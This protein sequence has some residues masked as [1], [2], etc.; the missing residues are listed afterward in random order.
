MLRSREA[1]SPPGEVAERA[2]SA[3]L[4]SDFP[5]QWS[6]D[7]S[8]RVGAAAKLA[9]GR[10]AGQQAAGGPEQVPGQPSSRGVDSTPRRLRSAY[11]AAAQMALEDLGAVEGLE[12]FVSVTERAL[13]SLEPDA[14]ARAVAMRRGSSQT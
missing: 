11:V 7:R 2:G 13:S 14:G 9:Q 8:E 5:S 12:R 10:E 4:S 6:R 3:S 1:H